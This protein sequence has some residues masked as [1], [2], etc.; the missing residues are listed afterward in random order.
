MSEKK[1]KN[2]RQTVWTDGFVVKVREGR[3]RKSMDENYRTGSSND[4]KSSGDGKFARRKG[5]KHETVGGDVPLRERMGRARM[6][7]RGERDGWSMCY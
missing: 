5:R 2:T 4:E 7:G 6:D 3:E 1:L